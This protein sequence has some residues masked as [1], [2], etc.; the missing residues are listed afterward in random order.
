MIHPDINAR[1]Q[2][3]KDD[4]HRL[5]YDD[6]EGTWEQTWWK[7]IKVLKCPLDLWVYQEILWNTKPKF[8][9]ECGTAHGGSAYFMADLIKTLGL[10]CR[11][12]TIDIEGS[13]TFPN[14]PSHELITYIHGSSTSAGTIATIDSMVGDS[15][16][17]VILDSAH[18][19]D[20]VLNEMN[21]Y[22]KYVPLN[23]YMIVEDGNVHGHP[24][25]PEHPEGPYEAIH[26]FIETN[27]DFVID[28]SCEKFHLT[29]N[30]DGYLKRVK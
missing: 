27:D 10:D 13:N 2:E 5:Y 26:A 28:Y 7:G 20:H 18:N 25:A 17:L 21:L 3:I 30:P 29:F 6:F 24:I 1:K 9:I 22:N 14:R 12:I 16:C 15:E 11:V 8:V 4:F 19:K 23:G